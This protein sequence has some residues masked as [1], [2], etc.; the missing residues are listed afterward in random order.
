MPNHNPVTQ[1]KVSY[2]D[3]DTA[4][5]AV[6]GTNETEC[7]LDRA[8]GELIY[9]T[10]DIRAFLE[11]KADALPDWAREEVAQAQRVLRALSEL[12]VD[13]NAN[14][15]NPDTTPNDAARYVAI[16]GTESHEA[17]EDMEEFVTTLRA[18]RVVDD[19]IR[20]LRGGKP[21]RRFKDALRDYPAEQER[22]YAFQQ[23]RLR[24]RIVEWAQAEGIELADSTDLKENEQ[25]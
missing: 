5:H 9:I 12:D 2:E 24:E 19:L 16:P 10:E 23:Q 22:W 14:E 6:S 17:F 25:A 21:F 4:F 7:W 1:S 3:L 11:D 15:G 8:T 20:A 18:G 13:E